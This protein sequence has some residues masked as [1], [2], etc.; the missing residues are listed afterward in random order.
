MSRRRNHD[1]AFKAQVA[2]AA[3]KLASTRLDNI[4][5]ERLWRSLKYQCFQLRA[6]E[7]GPQAK[8][9]IGRWIT[10]YNHH[11]PRAAH[12]GQPP[13]V[14]YFIAIETDQRVQAAA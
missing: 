14:V 4:L 9:G 5:I 8:A 13:A 6:R 11:Q 10:V 7:T 2:L 3:L 1:A 12:G